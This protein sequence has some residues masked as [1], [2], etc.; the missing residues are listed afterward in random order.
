[1]NKKKIVALMMALII[2]S[3]FSLIS[4]A[5]KNAEV[6]LNADTIEYNA[7]TGY[8]TA[9]GNVKM[10]KDGATL[11]GD[12]ALYNIKTKETNL[13]G[14]VKAQKNDAY[15]TANELKSTDGNCFI[16][17]GNVYF[18]RGQ[19]TMTSGKVEYYVDKEYVLAPLGGTLVTEGTKVTANKIE[20]FIKESKT[21]ATGNVYIVNKEKN[22]EATSDEAIH[23][24]GQGDKK[25]VL[26][27][28][29]KAVQN[30]NTL[31][32]KTLTIYLGDKNLNN[33]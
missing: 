15:M 31:S 27:G 9:E 20:S 7:E 12:K 3:T 28:N 32:G 2:L 23:Y 22:L 25:I 10:L 19:D 4:A 24:G 17:T 8:M 6:S 5:E 33:K 21:V 13:T 30:Q 11:T 26:V 18:K 16:A 14:N 29:A 1:M